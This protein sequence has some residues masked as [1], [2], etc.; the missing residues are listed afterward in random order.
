MMLEHAID[1]VL[2]DLEN[3]AWIPVPRPKAKPDV[4]PITRVGQSI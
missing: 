2:R 4:K 1:R 3:Y